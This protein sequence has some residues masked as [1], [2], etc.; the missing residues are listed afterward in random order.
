MILNGLGRMCA[1]E[2]ELTENIDAAGG[3]DTAEFAGKSID[4]FC[5]E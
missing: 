2:E 4:I 5:K 1:G 3:T